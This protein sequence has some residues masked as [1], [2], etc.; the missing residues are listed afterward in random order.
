MSL[1]WDTMQWPSYKL[2]E[3]NFLTDLWGKE[4]KMAPC[5]M[6]NGVR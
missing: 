1:S 3:I 6:F 5:N 2:Y 4:I